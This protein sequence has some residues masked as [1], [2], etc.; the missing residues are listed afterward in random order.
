M[1][2]VAHKGP[3]QGM[4]VAIHILVV[5]HKKILVVPFIEEYE[6]SI[7][8]TTVYVVAVVWEECAYY[9]QTFQYYI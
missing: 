2:V 4:P 3:G 9:Y 8:A 5:F 7:V 1:E 6:F